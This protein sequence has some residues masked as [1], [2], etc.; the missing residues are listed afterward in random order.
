M[1]E[2]S[3]NT[4]TVDTGF[5]V[6]RQH[7]VKAKFV[8]LEN[9]RRPTPPYNTHRGNKDVFSRVSF[10]FLDQDAP[11][12]DTVFTGSPGVDVLL[13]PSENLDDYMNLNQK[14]NTTLVSAVSTSRE[15][16]DA[17]N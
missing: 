9:P 12:P 3:N 17:F 1:L 2:Q 14:N 7:P 8:D 6:V 13:S 5:S 16:D 11:N 15:D 4:I 10:P